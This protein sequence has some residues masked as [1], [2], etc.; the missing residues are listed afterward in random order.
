GTLPFV[1]VAGPVL[2]L[3]VP[4]CPT[5]TARRSTAASDEGRNQPTPVFHARAAL[6]K[7]LWAASPAPHHRIEVSPRRPPRC[8]C[9]D[10]LVQPPARISTR[11]TLEIRAQP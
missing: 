6:G 11:G 1:G 3:G 9:L 5:K 10:T 8:G 7:C 2:N 4:L